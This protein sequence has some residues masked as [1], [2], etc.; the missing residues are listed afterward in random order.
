VQKNAHQVA[1]VST[2]TEP[3]NPEPAVSPAPAPT[4]HDGVVKITVTPPDARVSIDGRPVSAQDLARGISLSGGKHQLSAEA[5]GFDSYRQTLTV[6]PTTTQV[7]A[8]ALKE[9]VKSIVIQKGIGSLHVHSYPWA[10]IYIDGQFRGNTPTAQ[11]LA[12]AQGP[13]RLMLKQAGY[14]TYEETV[15]IK[16]GELA[17]VKVKLE[18]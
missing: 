6:D 8:V 16:D 17:R 10:E 12:L 18:K 2:P 11:P 9:I 15:E 1:M 14:R 5:A 13:H 3:R 7:V 4:P